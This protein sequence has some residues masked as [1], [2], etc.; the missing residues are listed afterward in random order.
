[1]SDA[2]DSTASR[3]CEDGTGV[4]CVGFGDHPPIN[5]SV[6]RGGSASRVWRQVSLGR[7]PEAFAAA[8]VVVSPVAGAHSHDC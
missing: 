2:G 4:G 6:A 5:P 3:K 7:N 1:M 8:R